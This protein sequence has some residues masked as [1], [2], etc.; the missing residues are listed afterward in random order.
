[1][2]SSNHL[3]AAPIGHIVIHSTATSPDTLFKEFKQF[4]CHYLIAA[5]GR[6]TCIREVSFS[7]TRVDIALVGGVDEKGAYTD[8]R[9]PEQ[10][11]TLFNT[12]IYLSENFRDAAIV[13]ADEL[14]P[15]PFPNPGFC[16]RQWLNRNFI[17]SQ[18]PHFYFK[19][20]R[21]ERKTNSRPHRAWL[22][23]I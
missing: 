9:S 15:Y 5:S 1:M 8:T 16:I 14:L 21:H 2:K 18:H 3:P 4:P 13:G 7:D 12:L 20:I 11:D 19:T 23:G 22:Q 10:C 17:L 6:L